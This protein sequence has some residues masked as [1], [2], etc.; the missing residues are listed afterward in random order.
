M[1]YE[2]GSEGKPCEAVSGYAGVTVMDLLARPSEEFMAAQAANGTSQSNTVA[3]FTDKP[4][5]ET[6]VIHD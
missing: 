2:I 5:S 1:S 3:T 4:D 6:V